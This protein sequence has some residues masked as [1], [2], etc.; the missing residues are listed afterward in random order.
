[1]KNTLI[2]FS[3]ALVACSEPADHSSSIE[4]S[5]DKDTWQ[6][7]ISNRGSMLNDFL[8]KHDITEQDRASIEQ[9]L[10]DPDGY[11]LY[12]EFPAY[13]LKEKGDCVVAFPIDRNT[14]KVKEVVIEPTDCITQAN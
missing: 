4:T 8:S 9:L 14:G 3:L 5:F 1:M 10:G 12:D 6:S 7:N 2:F 11:Y 13:R